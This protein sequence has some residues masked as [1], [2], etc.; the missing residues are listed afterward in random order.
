MAELY[1]WTAVVF[2]TCHFTKS[3]LNQ[4]FMESQEAIPWALWSGKFHLYLWMNLLAE[5]ESEEPWKWRQSR[6]MSYPAVVHTLVLLETW[7]TFISSLNVLILCSCKHSYTAVPRWYYV[8]LF[9][10]VGFQSNIAWENDYPRYWGEN[11]LTASNSK[12]GNKRI[13]V[14]TNHFFSFPFPET[15]VWSYKWKRQDIWWEW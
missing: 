6:N 15:R 13:Q 12:G 8:F 9:W 7:I 14:C 1:V 10:L 5:V 3:D 4:F 11:R 2:A